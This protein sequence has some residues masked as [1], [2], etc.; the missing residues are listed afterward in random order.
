MLYEVITNSMQE[1]LSF[2]DTVKDA[3]K[4]VVN[5]AAKRRV[6]SNAAN[7]P[8]QMFNDPFLR[9]FFGDQFNEQF[10]QNR[11]QRSLGSGVIISKDGYIVTNNHVVENADE[12]SVTIGDNSYNFV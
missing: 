2:N 7:I 12:I 10:N 11:I 9:R 5:I 3:M 1:I 8:F 4:S 6:I